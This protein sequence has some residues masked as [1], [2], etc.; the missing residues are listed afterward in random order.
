MLIYKLA[1]R[2]IFHEIQIQIIKKSLSIQIT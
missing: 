2:G 1:I